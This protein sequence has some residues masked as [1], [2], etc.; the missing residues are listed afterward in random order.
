VSLCAI[1]PFQTPVSLCA[2][3]FNLTPHLFR[4]WRARLIRLLLPRRVLPTFWSPET[5]LN[6]KMSWGRFDEK[7]FSSQKHFLKTC[8]CPFHRRLG[9]YM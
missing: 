7:S 9:M 1:L 8:L 2:V 5:V 6:K 3:L 4:R